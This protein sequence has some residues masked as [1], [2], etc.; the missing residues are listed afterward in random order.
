MVLYQ[1]GRT[2]GLVLDGG[3]GLTWTM[4]V[5]EGFTMAHGSQ[6]S[7]NG[8][9]DLTEWVHENLI[10]KCP[11]ANNLDLLTAR[12]IKEKCCQVTNESYVEKI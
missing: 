11:W 1:H 12:D 8:G 5:F 7:H 9:R 4:P 10:K 6:T 2:T 3:D